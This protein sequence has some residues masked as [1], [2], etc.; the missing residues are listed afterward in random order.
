MYPHRHTKGG[1]RRSSPST[2][3]LRVCPDDLQACKGGTRGKR[4][5]EP[6][7]RRLT[8]PEQGQRERSRTA[9]GGLDDNVYRKQKV[10]HSRLKQTCSERADARPSGRSESIKQIKIIR[11]WIHRI[12]IG[13]IPLIGCEALSCSS[14]RRYP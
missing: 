1:N 9:N 7:G 3:S 4:L 10:P 13:L 11:I 8:V 5:L 14:G 6:Q 12:G 2:G